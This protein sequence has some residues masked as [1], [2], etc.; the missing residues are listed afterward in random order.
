MPRSITRRCTLALG[1]LM[2]VVVLAACDP[3]ASSGLAIRALSPASGLQPGDRV[4]VRLAGAQPDQVLRYA[5]CAS[6][7]ACSPTGSARAGADG[8]VTVDL[9][10]GGTAPLGVGASAEERACR[11]DRCHIVAHPAGAPGAAVSLPLALTGEKITADFGPTDALADG[12]VVAVSGRVRGAEGATVRLVQECA[13]A[14]CGGRT[15]LA[16]APVGS[17]GSFSLSGTVRLSLAGGSGSC[18]GASQPCRLAVRVLRTPSAFDTSFGTASSRLR[19]VEPGPTFTVDRMVEGATAHVVGTVPG[20][21]AGRV[22]V[23]QA[24]CDDPFAGGDQDCAVTSGVVVDIVGGRFEASFTAQR[25]IG[26]LD[27]SRGRFPVPECT[28]EALVVDVAGAPDPAYAI[29]RVAA[30]VA[31]P[32]PSATVTPATD[33]A[34]RTAVTVSGQANVPAGLDLIVRHVGCDGGGACVTGQDVVVVS[35]GADGAFSTPFTVRRFVGGVDCGLPDASCALQVEVDSDSS[36]YATTR[37]A[38]DIDGSKVPIIIT[39]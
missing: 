22:R 8:A 9:T 21:A 25:Q 13:G 1:A 27:C 36:L 33:I 29:G 23:R 39:G 35:P 12:G 10:V 38:I 24:A 19:F 6:S 17:D 4:S 20:L 34:D 11:P 15:T 32:G 18:A 3:P 7:A 31:R 14:G 26:D 30:P 2:L 16:D 28:V 5:Q 37:L